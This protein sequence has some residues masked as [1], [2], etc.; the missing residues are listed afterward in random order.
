M[1]AWTVTTSIVVKT[2]RTFI[3]QKEINSNPS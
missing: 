2:L 3:F 1:H